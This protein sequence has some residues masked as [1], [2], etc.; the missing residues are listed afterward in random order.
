MRTKNSIKFKSRSVFIVRN[1]LCHRQ[2]IEQEFELI[3]SKSFLWIKQSHEVNMIGTIVLWTRVCYKPRIFLQFTL[4]KS[5][6]DD[7]WMVLMTNTRNGLGIR[8]FE[9]N[10]TSA[11]WAKKRMIDFF[12]WSCNVMK[13][14]INRFFSSLCR[15]GCV[16]H[17]SLY[18][19]WRQESVIRK[20][21]NW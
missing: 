10:L 21:N 12:Y 4:F 13:V 14:E 1:G 5:Y 8:N 3:D 6:S 18:I 15:I 20:V 17:T 11:P 19:I 16:V 2:S 7:S 9:S